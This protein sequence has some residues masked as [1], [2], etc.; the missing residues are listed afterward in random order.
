MLKQQ[1]FW[2]GDG[3]EPSGPGIEGQGYALSSVSHIDILPRT[4]SIAQANKAFSISRVSGL[5]RV[6][7]FASARPTYKI[8]EC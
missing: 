2:G 8:R 1:N 3:R 6:E 7:K 4:N 5:R